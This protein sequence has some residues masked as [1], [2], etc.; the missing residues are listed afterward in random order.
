MAKLWDNI[1]LVLALVLIAEGLLPF[2]A[3]R[4]W[5][6]VFLKLARMRDGQVRFMG[7]ASLLFGILLLLLMC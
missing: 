7:L 4:L 6:Q 3:P 1:G 2:T 5:R